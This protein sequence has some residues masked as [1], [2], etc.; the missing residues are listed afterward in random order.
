MFLTPHFCMAL[1]EWFP[2]LHEESFALK[3]T[4]AKGAVKALTV[5][6][7]VEGLHPSV[8]SL[9]GKPARNT[10]GREQLV[11]IFFTIWK[12]VLKVKW[13]IGEDFATVSANETLRMEGLTHRLQT[14]PKNF[15]S[16]LFTRW[17]QVFPVAIFTI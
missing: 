6:V 8:S 2:G 1:A 12:T 16:A 15:L 9:D 4:F 13:R 17:S 5:V 14:I 10:L 11:P 3:V 7:V